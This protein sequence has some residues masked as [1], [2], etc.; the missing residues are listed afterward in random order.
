MI[1]QWNRQ[2]TKDIAD[3]SFSNGSKR[4]EVGEAQIV[5]YKTLFFGQGI[6][7]LSHER[8]KEMVE[9]QS[10]SG[11][12]HRLPV[13]ASGYQPLLILLHGQMREL[14]E[15]EVHTHDR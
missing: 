13:G 15:P 9:S 14:T 8:R 1:A 11:L 7:S 2:V 4:K 3:D 5:D 12:E 6:R 10:F